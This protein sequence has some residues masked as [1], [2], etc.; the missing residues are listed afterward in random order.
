[1]F[2]PFDPY[3]AAPPSLNDSVLARVPPFLEHPPFLPL[4]DPPG[5]PRLFF[6]PSA[7]VELGQDH[8]GSRNFPLLDASAFFD[9]MRKCTP[10]RSLHPLVNTPLIDAPRKTWGFSNAKNSSRREAFSPFS[11]RR[12]KEF[13]RPERSPLPGGRPTGLIRPPSLPRPRGTKNAKIFFLKFKKYP[14]P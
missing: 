13:F 2:W 6:V 1:M 5:P 7:A 3:P 14:V 12:P 9:S 8:P 4:S 11:F 10:P